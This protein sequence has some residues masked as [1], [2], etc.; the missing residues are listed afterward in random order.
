MNIESS[1]RLCLSKW[2][3]LEFAKLAGVQRKKRSLGLRR[4][5]SSRPRIPILLELLV[6]AHSVLRWSVYHLHTYELMRIYG[7]IIA[8]PEH[9]RSMAM[10]DW[11]TYAACE[12]LPN[13]LKCNWHIQVETTPRSQTSIYHCIG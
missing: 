6:C 10:I 2:L 11:R 1:G 13:N 7:P 3:P 5:D 8:R 9:I 4:S 12:R